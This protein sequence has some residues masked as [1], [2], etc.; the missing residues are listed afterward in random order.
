MCFVFLPPYCSRK[1]RATRKRKCYQPPLELLLVPENDMWMVKNHKHLALEKRVFLFQKT[2]R[3]KVGLICFL[4]L[5]RCCKLTT[6]IQLAV[7][8]GSRNA[9][10]EMIPVRLATSIVIPVSRK[11][12]EKSITFSLPELIFSEVMTR[13]FFVAGTFTFSLHR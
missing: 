5:S 3:M 6:S 9:V 8:K 7:S 10:G 13:S 11:G 12:T 4:H 1:V 2:F